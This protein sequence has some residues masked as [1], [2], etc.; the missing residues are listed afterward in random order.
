MASG[1]FLVPEQV[2]VRVEQAFD[3]QYLLQFGKR[4]PVLIDTPLGTV[5]FLRQ[6]V[7]VVREPFVPADVGRGIYRTLPSGLPDVEREPCRER[8]HM[9]AETVRPAIPVEVLERGHAG[10]FQYGTYPFGDSV[11]SLYPV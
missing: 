11:L 8:H 2:A 5:V 7:R 9:V 6:E 4:P 10:K 1:S 3:F